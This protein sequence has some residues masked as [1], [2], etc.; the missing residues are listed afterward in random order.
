[1]REAPPGDCGAG[2]YAHVD[3]VLQAAFFLVLHALGPVH[4]S[5]TEW[6]F[7]SWWSELDGRAQLVEL[8]AEHGRGVT[9]ANALD[10]LRRA[11]WEWGSFSSRR[12]FAGELT[13]S[14][15]RVSSATDR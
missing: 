5:N 4:V 8:A 11:K 7:V 6:H 13:H 1:M 9:V 10:V 2:R 3:G 14:L 15:Y 12:I